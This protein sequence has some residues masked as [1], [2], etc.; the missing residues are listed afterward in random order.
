MSILNDVLEDNDSIDPSYVAA[1]EL[2]VKIA[3][4]ADV[5]LDSF[6]DEEVGDMLTE[7]V[8][9]DSPES[10]DDGHSAEAETDQAETA[11]G[12]DM[13]QKAASITAGVV[14]RE[15]AKIASSEGIDLADLSQEEY[16]T[17]FNH[18]ADSMTEPTY[19]EKQA[20]AQEKLAEADA[21][22]RAMAHSFDDELRKIAS[23]E[24]QEKEASRAQMA[25]E[26]L[27]QF[28]STGA[29]KAKGAVSAGAKKLKGLEASA[30][31][32]VGGAV[33]SRGPGKAVHQKMKERIQGGIPRNAMEGAEAG[34]KARRIL[35]RAAVG[36]AATGAGAGTY[37]ATRDKKSFNEDVLETARAA[38]LEAGIDPDTGVKVAEDYDTMVAQAAVELLEA[39]G[40]TFEG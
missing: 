39:N 2:L 28:A 6:S 25:G 14:A 24:E 9:D 19:F 32:A 22:G 16:D 18:L 1:G 7:L 29:K 4:E 34:A 20:A 10:A 31:E 40:Y 3:E 17:A 11:T 12:E 15:L 36:T 21:I 38:L 5:D 8:N 27:K 26:T 23:F 33:S 13:T 37:A 35:G 30:S